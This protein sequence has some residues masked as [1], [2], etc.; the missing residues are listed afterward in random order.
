M[1]IDTT[2]LTAYRDTMQELF[3]LLNQAYN[4]A[5]SLDAEIAINDLAD[6]VSAILTQLNQQG[7]ADDTAQLEALQ[8]SVDAVNTQLATAQA[9]VN[10]WV[11]DL[12]DAAQIAGVMDKAVQLAGT[13]F[14]A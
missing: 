5:P 9:Q 6:A 10:N 7:L 11:K 2:N 13:I 14:A 4:S 3:N 1:T 12:G 8:P